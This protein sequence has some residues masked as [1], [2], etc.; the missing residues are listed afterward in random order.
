MKTLS[1]FVRPKYTR[2]GVVLTGLAWLASTAAVVSGQEAVVLNVK[3]AVRLGFQSQPGES[4]QLY[5]STN[6]TNWETYGDIQVGTGQEIALDYVTEGDSM[7]L[8]RAA[9][10]TN[11]IRDLP[12]F[13]GYQGWRL[14]TRHIG[15]NPLLGPGIHGGTN[16]FKFIY[17]YPTGARL[18]NGRIPIGTIV[19]KETHENNNGQPGAITGALTIMAKRGGTFDPEGNGWEFFMTDTNLTQTLLRGGSETMC[20]A[21][22]S[23]AKDSDFMFSAA[24]LEAC[25]AS[26]K[27]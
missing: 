8:F 10:L 27:P 18:Y 20:Y 24:E 1:L 9:T 11:V 21:C 2:S 7:N 16:V 19:V 4:Y 14:F 6:L 22:H 23:A 25:G 26:V 13:K 5:R 17:V 3:R 12:D 15:P